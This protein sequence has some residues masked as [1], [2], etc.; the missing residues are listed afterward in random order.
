MLLSGAAVVDESSLTGESMPVR[1]RGVRGAAAD[2][3]SGAAA[4][5]AR[6]HAQHTILA[7]TTVLQMSAEGGGGGGGGGAGGGGAGGIE[8]LLGSLGPKGG[9]L[10]YVGKAL[11][12]KRHV[13][14][15]WAVVKRW[16]PLLF[17]GVLL[18]LWFKPLAELVTALLGK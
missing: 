3:A 14:S 17:L 7:G 5:E 10:G 1:K 6:R 8:A 2:K 18:L 12:V 11:A 16:T 15:A 4:W 13:D 9:A